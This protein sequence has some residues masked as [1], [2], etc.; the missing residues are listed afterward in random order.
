MSL[1]Y[2]VGKY[3]P[4][5][6]YTEFKEPYSKDIAPG[7]ISAGF[8]DEETGTLDV[9]YNTLAFGTRYDINPR[10]ALKVEYTIF[11]DEGDAAV[12]IDENQ[13]GMTDSKGVFVGLDFK[14]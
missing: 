9:D 13:D 5:V 11:S 14:F 2:R 8:E 3:T 10:L 1:A 4:Y 12:F 6:Y 7:G